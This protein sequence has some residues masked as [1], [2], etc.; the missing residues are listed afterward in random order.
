M[1]GITFYMLLY[2]TARLVLTDKLYKNLSRRKMSCSIDFRSSLEHWRVNSLLCCYKT[3]TL[4]G[5]YK[6]ELCDWVLLSFS[7]STP[8][9]LA[10]RQILLL[11]ALVLVP[12]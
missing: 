3:C 4:H 11:S 7:P 2:K 9:K 6:F 8:S 5:R 1:L 12:Q 10:I